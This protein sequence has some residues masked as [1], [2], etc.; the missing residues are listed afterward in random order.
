[1][2]ME[3][4]PFLKKLEKLFLSMNE[5]YDEAASY[6]DFHCHG[7]DE[8]CCMTLFHH[9]TYLEFFYLKKG[10]E[11]LSPE[12]K[13]LVYDRAAKV[14]RETKKSDQKT[15]SGKNHVSRQCQ[16]QVCGILSSSHDLQAS[17]NT[18]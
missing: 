9:H 10:F 13:K 7:C 14:C 12:L 15:G 18:Q 16:R 3:L 11:S 1:M 4:G 8:N 2:D 6:Y 5:K 17:W